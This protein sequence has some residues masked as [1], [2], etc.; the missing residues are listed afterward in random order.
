M[1]VCGRKSGPSLPVNQ[2]PDTEVWNMSDRF[3]PLT[4][5]MATAFIS[6]LVWL[7][8]MVGHFAR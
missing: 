3:G 5:V 6:T 8:A 1:K 7:S 4:F 2:H